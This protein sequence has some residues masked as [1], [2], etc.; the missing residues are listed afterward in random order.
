MEDKESILFQLQQLMWQAMRDHSMSMEELMAATGRS[1]ECLAPLL[2]A[3]GS[4]N[5]T[6]IVLVLNALEIPWNHLGGGGGS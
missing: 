4:P 2:H 3:K 6:T 5:L 1:R